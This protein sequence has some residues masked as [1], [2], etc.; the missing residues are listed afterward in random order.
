M[1]NITKAEADA[2]IA[3]PKVISANLR[4]QPWHRGFRLNG[5]TGAAVV[6]LNSEQILKLSGYVGRKNR[7]FALLFKNQRIRGYCVKSRRRNPDG[8]IISGPHKHSWEDLDE[9]SWAYVPTDVR[10]G[11]VNIELLDFLTEC[12]VELT[13]SYRA[14]LL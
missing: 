5:S 4:W 13:S 7:S 1:A 3:E 2:I 10:S 14:Q 9:D 8:Q 6:A 12:N 11:D